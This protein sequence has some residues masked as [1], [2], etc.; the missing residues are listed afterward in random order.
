MKKTMAEVAANIE[1]RATFHDV[2][3]LLEAKLERTEVQYM[4]QQKVSFEEMKSYVD[5]ANS[6]RYNPLQ[7]ELEQDMRVIK[8]RLEDTVHQITGL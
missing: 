4:I 1:S 2:K 8:R 7:E 3:R 5:Q 6:V